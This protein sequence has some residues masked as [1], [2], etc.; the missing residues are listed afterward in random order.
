MKISNEIKEAVKD[1]ALELF[2]NVS[3]EEVNDITYDSNNKTIVVEVANVDLFIEKENIVYGVRLPMEDIWPSW[4]YAEIAEE[5]P[6]AGEAY[7]KLL[8]LAQE[9]GLILE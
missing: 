1:F 7:D 2:W 4:S 8:H 6:E 5:R 9:Q 3:E